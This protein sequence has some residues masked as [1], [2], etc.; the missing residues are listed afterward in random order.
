MVL[1]VKYPSPDSLLRTDC[2]SAL[3]T[4][5]LQ[6]MKKMEDLNDALK[7]FPE[8]ADLKM[9]M[10]DV[11][12]QKRVGMVEVELWR[13]RQELLHD[14]SA[15]I[16]P[17]RPTYRRHGRPRLTPPGLLQCEAAAT[18]HVFKMADVN[19][20]AASDAYLAE[21]FAPLQEMESM[22]M[23]KPLKG[24]IGSS[25]N[26]GIDQNMAAWVTHEVQHSSPSMP[27]SMPPSMSHS[28]PPSDNI[29]HS[30][31]D[32]QNTLNQLD[33]LIFILHSLPVDPNLARERRRE[34]Q[35]VG[36]IGATEATRDRG[37]KRQ[38]R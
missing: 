14:L 15:E 30:K 20:A 37:R 27:P 34:S 24:V 16:N 25:A 8:V 26:T 4:E 36:A 33:T 11:E 2:D 12:F 23:V 6:L 38:R 32:Y 3:E 7:E 5:R 21:I 17:L 28:M 22:L 29:P 31:C 1:F 35:H 10:K 9:Q 13:R 18:G 19:E